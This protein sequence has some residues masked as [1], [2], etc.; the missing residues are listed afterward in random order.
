MEVWGA[1]MRSDVLITNKPQQN[2]VLSTI[3]G[4]QWRDI[5]FEV[6]K[7]WQAVNP[8]CNSV[9]IEAVD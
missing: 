8:T 7:S 1:R 4:L 9:F 6:A 3:Y 2:H 5:Q